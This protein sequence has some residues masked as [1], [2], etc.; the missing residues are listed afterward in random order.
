[1]IASD[2][3]TDSDWHGI[4]DGTD[5]VAKPLPVTIAK[6]VWIGEGHNS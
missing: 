6:N 4:Y 2:V 1:M 3:V 5:Y